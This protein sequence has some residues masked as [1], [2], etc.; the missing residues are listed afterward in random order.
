MES[1]GATV[2]APNYIRRYSGAT[3]RQELVCKHCGGSIAQN[4]NPREVEYQHL[5]LVDEGHPGY[6]CGDE[7][8][9]LAE[10]A[11]AEERER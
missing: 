9:P 10:P 1:A 8:S 6:H 5:D 3:G 2:T 7:N 4:G 11:A